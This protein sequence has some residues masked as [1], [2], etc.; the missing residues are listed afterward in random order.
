MN[1]TEIIDRHTR[2]VNQRN[3]HKNK[4]GLNYGG[5]DSDDADQYDKLMQ[6]EISNLGQIHN[7]RISEKSKRALGIN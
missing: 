6:R 1:K 7:H 4:H 5:F 3:A 2:A